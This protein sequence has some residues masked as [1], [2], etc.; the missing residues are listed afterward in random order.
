M[1]RDRRPGLREPDRGSGPD[2]AAGA[3]DENDLI[4]EIKK[5]HAPNP[6]HDHPARRP[7][8]SLMRTGLLIALFAVWPV[9]AVAAAV[10][11][12]VRARFI[13]V[14]A[15]TWV[16]ALAI[17][18]TATGTRIAAPIG[19]MIGASACLFLAFAVSSGV[20][21]IFNPDTTYDV[22]DGKKPPAEYVVLGV[23]ALVDAAA[24]ALAVP[25]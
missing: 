5:T 4:P 11:G 24:I 19:L 13:L 22:D 21:F 17:A 12:R 18:T 7:K 2:P 14:C 25:G 15:G 23:V 10:V 9:T 6:R 16:L 20:T 8:V 3:G 1:Q